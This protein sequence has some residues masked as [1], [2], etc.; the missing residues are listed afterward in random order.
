MPAAGLGRRVCQRR[1]PRRHGRC[2]G[3]RCADAVRIGCALAAD[4][5]RARAVLPRR[6]A[7]F[8][9]TMP[10]DTPGLTACKRP[11]RRHPSAGGT[12]PCAVLGWTHEWAKTRRGYGVIKR[13][14]LGTRLRRCRQGLG[15]WCRDNRPAPRQE[16]EQT[17]SLPRRGADPDDG[18]RGN[19]KRLA[20]VC[21]PPERAWPDWL[22]RRRHTGPLTWQTCGDAGPRK[23]PLPTPRSMHHIEE[24]LGQQ[25]DAPNGVSPVW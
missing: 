15:T 7:R 9:R 20:V 23:R 24:R 4:A 16:P 1:A 21:E 14:T 2:W 22:S 18:R 13:Q 6:L 12:G 8:R 5:R 11:P 17:V 3:T 19:V 25:R 10:P